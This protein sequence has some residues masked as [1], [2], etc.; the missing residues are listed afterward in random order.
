[1]VLGVSKS[2]ASN[3]KLRHYHFTAFDRRCRRD[4]VA[5]LHVARPQGQ[6]VRRGQFAPRAALGEA[7][8]HGVTLA[9][10]RSPKTD[11]IT[12]TEGPQK[13]ADREN[14]LGLS[15]CFFGGQIRSLI[16]K[17]PAFLVNFDGRHRRNS[18]RRNSNC[19][20]RD[21]RSGIA[22]SSSYRGRDRA[23]NSPGS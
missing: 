22:V 14:Y 20:A 13:N 17:S 12:E 1:M 4:I 5:G 21:Q 15:Q 18:C 3:F 9:R 19:M 2:M 16:S 10:G 6:P 23:T 11:A 8:A 7:P